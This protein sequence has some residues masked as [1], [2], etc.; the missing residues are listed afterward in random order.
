MQ[1]ITVENCSSLLE[2]AHHIKI[3][4]NPFEDQIQIEL[5]N[6][7]KYSL[8]NI[9]GQIVTQGFSESSGIIELNLA[10]IESGMYY[11]MLKSHLK[12]STIPI[13]KR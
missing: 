7:T 12:H 8:I 13:V 1:E 5:P 9:Q 2:L 6:N 3:W 4:P 11:V 10:N